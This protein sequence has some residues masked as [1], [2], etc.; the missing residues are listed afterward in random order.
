[1]GKYNLEKLNELN[2]AEVL[3]AMGAKASKSNKLLHCPNTEAHSHGDKHPSMGFD[4]RKNI[5]KCFVCDLSGNPVTVA[6]KHFGDFKKACEFL[7]ET[8]NVPYLSGEVSH[9]SPKRLHPPKSREK[10]YWSFD[11]HKKFVKVLIKDFLPKYS[12]M[13]EIQRLKLI[14]TFVYR[15]SLTTDQRGK[16]AWYYSRGL[17]E[18]KF[19]DHLGFLSKS[20]ID[21]L[22]EQLLK[23]F[24]LEELQRLKLLDLLG[25]WKYGYNTIVVP[26]FDLYSDMVE[27]FMLRYTDNRS[28]GKEAN[29]SCTDIAFP[30]PF[31]LGRKTIQNCKNIWLTEGHVDGLSIATQDECFISLSGI[32]SYK[33]E[34]LGLLRGKTVIVAFDKD[35]AGQKAQKVLIERLVNAGVNYKLAL[36]DAKDGEDLNELLVN[37]KIKKINVENGEN[38]NGNVKPVI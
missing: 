17:G 13:S 36:W 32:Y 16:L 14:Y 12:S 33:E 6:T 19:L 34:M 35:N 4:A 8:F 18:S 21:T 30:L 26:S 11:S 27:G 7:H 20:D 10:Q 23:Y 29:V 5:C 3:M 31:G 38:E 24:S 25:G 9:Q 37:G 15:F 22:V 1:M 2:I 28:K